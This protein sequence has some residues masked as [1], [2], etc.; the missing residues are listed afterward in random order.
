MSQRVICASVLLCL[1][2]RRSGRC[3]WVTTVYLVVEKSKSWSVN[4]RKD[5]LA[6]IFNYSLIQEVCIQFV[7]TVLKRLLD[8]FM[9]KVCSWDLV[10]KLWWFWLCINTIALVQSIL[11]CANSRVTILMNYISKNAPGNSF[12]ISEIKQISSHYIF[13]S[14]HN[15]R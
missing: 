6:A 2:L 8:T 15:S 5:D 13:L 3:Q 10:N 11:I 1:I 12:T 4:Q 9:N 14:S 7:P